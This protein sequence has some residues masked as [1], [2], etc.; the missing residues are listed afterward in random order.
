MQAVREKGK[1]A[2]RYREAVKRYETKELWLVLVVEWAF[3]LDLWLA[4]Q[5]QDGA[6]T[7]ALGCSGFDGVFFS[8]EGLG[9]TGDWKISECG[10]DMMLRSRGSGG[11]FGRCR[12]GWKG[13]LRDSQRWGDGR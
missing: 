2:D 7:A 8:Q 6:L 11:S 5:D 12:H 3:G 9:V 4:L 13:W 10:T 1:L